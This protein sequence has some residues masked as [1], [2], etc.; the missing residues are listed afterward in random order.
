M[1]SPLGLRAGVHR[2]TKVYIEPSNSDCMAPS[3]VIFSSIFHKKYNINKNAQGMK[4]GKNKG[5]KEEDPWITHVTPVLH[6]L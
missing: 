5:S 1:S 4:K 6:T 3:N 2:N